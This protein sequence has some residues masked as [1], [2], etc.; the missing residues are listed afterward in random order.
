MTQTICAVWA[1]LGMMNDW[2]PIFSGDQWASRLTELPVFRMG[3]EDSVVRDALN[4][5][6]L[7]FFGSPQAP[8][9]RTLYLTTF[10]LV[11]PR[12]VKILVSNGTDVNLKNGSGKDR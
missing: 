12:L 2:D 8:R 10:N 5:K 9:P 4:V 3:R 1:G 6:L 11:P 7:S